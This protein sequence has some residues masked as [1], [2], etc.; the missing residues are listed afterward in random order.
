[1]E[2]NFKV[3]D[4]VTIYDAGK[5]YKSGVIEKMATTRFGEKVVV[6][7]ETGSTWIGFL[8]NLRKI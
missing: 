1:M 3:G 2:Q 5:P 4:K 6:K 7:T 8:K